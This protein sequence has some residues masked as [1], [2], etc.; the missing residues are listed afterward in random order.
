[1]TMTQENDHPLVPEILHEDPQSV[2]GPGA[3]ESHLYLGEARMNLSH[4]IDA[5]RKRNLWQKERGRPM[6]RT[7]TLCN[8]S[9]ASG[10]GRH[11][12]VLYKCGSKLKSVRPAEVIVTVLGKDGEYRCHF[13]GRASV[14][15]KASGG[16]FLEKD[17]RRVNHPERRHRAHCREHRQSLGFNSSNWRKDY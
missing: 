12:L 16:H 8:A 4:A 13:Q 1:M 3:I 10:G 2:L 6:C 11:S 7:N 14:A 17:F 9:A 5:H 15:F